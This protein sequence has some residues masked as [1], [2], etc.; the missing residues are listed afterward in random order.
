M[1]VA[2]RY[3]STWRVFTSFPLRSKQKSDLSY[4][5]RFSFVTPFVLVQSGPEL[6]R[7]V[8]SELG[9]FGQVQSVQPSYATS[10]VVVSSVVGSVSS[11]VVV[12]FGSGSMVPPLFTTIL[13]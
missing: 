11:T 10:S 3:H 7:Q 8:P 1:N 2:R 9:R 5:G 13:P 6:F 4:V 12:S